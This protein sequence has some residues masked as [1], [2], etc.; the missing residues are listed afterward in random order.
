MKNL[1]GI[2]QESVTLT[3]EI[4]MKEV[5]MKGKTKEQFIQ[6][7]HRVNGHL[8]EDE[9]VLLQEDQN[10]REAA[11]A[12]KGAVYGVY[13]SVGRKKPSGVKSSD[14]A[15]EIAIS[16]ITMGKQEWIM[17]KYKDEKGKEIITYDDGGCVGRIVARMNAEINYGRA[18]ENARNGR[19][20][21]VEHGFGAGVIVIRND[22]G[23]YID[24]GSL[25]DEVAYKAKEDAIVRNLVRDLEYRYN[26]RQEKKQFALGVMEELKAKIKICDNYKDIKA[27][28]NGAGGTLFKRLEAEFGNGYV[29]DNCKL[30]KDGEETTMNKWFLRYFYKQLWAC[31]DVSAWKLNTM[32]AYDKVQKK[33]DNMQHLC[34]NAYHMADMLRSNHKAFGI[35]PKEARI[36]INYAKA[37]RGTVRGFSKPVFYALCEVSKAA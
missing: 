14:M 31:V 28:I 11:A 12:I 2:N 10:F 8:L 25:N 17:S 13:D 9:V 15:S 21:L 6:E 1:K 5:T 7:W 32:T 3:K 36:A 27:I 33:L 16:N 20:D 30:I 24:K 22:K 19:H 35:S 4:E 37:N 29:A 23:Q 26:R 18:N 34:D